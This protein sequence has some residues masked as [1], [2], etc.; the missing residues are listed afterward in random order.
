MF[1]HFLLPALKGNGYFLPHGEEFARD[2][3][4]SVKNWQ[5]FLELE[6]VRTSL[7]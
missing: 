6:G 4:I 3:A 2:L 1:H 5:A 7:R